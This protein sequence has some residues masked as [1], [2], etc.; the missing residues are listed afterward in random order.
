[1]GKV[2]ELWKHTV[3][4][5]AKAKLEEIED[6]GEVEEK[7]QRTIKEMYARMAALGEVNQALKTGGKFHGDE[8]TVFK[9]MEK[10]VKAPEYLSR[11]EMDIIKQKVEIYE[12]KLKNID[13]GKEERKERIRK[14]KERVAEIRETQEENFLKEIIGGEEK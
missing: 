1:M 8:E 10:A 14:L 4:R 3:A 9:L 2:A 13:V 5:E 11:G 6:K 12:Q 7:A